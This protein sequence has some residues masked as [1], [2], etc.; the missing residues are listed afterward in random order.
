MY[1]F[2]NIICDRVPYENYILYA[3]SSLL[4]HILTVT[5]QLC[6]VPARQH[7]KEATKL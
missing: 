4:K 7:H 3:F 2:L 5:L 6:N 1:R